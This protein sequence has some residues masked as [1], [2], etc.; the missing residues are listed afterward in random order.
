[1][2]TDGIIEEMS[3]ALELLLFL[4]ILFDRAF[5]LKFPFKKFIFVVYC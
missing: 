1:M 5:A 2:Q 3:F 4:L